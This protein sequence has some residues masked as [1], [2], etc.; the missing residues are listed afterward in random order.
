M[1]FNFTDRETYLAWRLEWRAN[2]MDLSSRIRAQKRSRK[3]FLRS[4]ENEMTTLGRV[5][6]LVSKWPNPEFGSPGREFLS[7]LQCEATLQ[8]EL[9]AE[10]KALSWV[11]RQARVA[12]E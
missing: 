9:L 4:Y 11:L 5:R 8:L 7:D 12:Q 6:R 1:K 2:Y 3:Q 10:A